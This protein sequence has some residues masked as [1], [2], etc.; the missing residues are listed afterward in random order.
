MLP[1]HRLLV[2]LLPRT[3][4]EVSLLIVDERPR[5]VVCQPHLTIEDRKEDPPR[6]TSLERVADSPPS[7]LRVGNP[8]R[9]NVVPRNA[10]PRLEWCPLF[11]HSVRNGDGPGDLR[12]HGPHAEERLD[13][14][15]LRQRPDPL[16]RLPVRET[17]EEHHELDEVP[18]TLA[19]KTQVTTPLASVRANEPVGPPVFQVVLPVR[20]ERALLGPDP[21]ALPARRD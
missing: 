9:Q 16:A 2:R 3:G 5:C 12:E 19:T 1:E 18:R 14:L 20:R 15:L 4:S 13:R 6:E 8:S 7:D 17:P 10:V 11:L 21:V